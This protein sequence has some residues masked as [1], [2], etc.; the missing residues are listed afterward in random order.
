[1]VS[2]AS[3]FSFNICIHGL[4]SLLFSY[5]TFPLEHSI[6][7][8]W[9]ELLRYWSHHVPVHQTHIHVL[10]DALLFLSLVVFPQIRSSY[11]S[12]SHLST[13]QLDHV[14]FCDKPFNGFLLLLG[15]NWDSKTRIPKPF[16]VWP[17]PVSPAALSPSLC[18][19]CFLV[20]TVASIFPRCLATPFCSSFMAQRGFPWAPGKFRF[21]CYVF[22][23]LFSQSY[24]LLLFIEACVQVYRFQSTP[25]LPW[26]WA[27][28]APMS[29]QNSQQQVLAVRGTG[30]GGCWG[31]MVEALTAPLAVY[32]SHC[33]DPLMLQT[34]F[35]LA[36]HWF[37]KV[38]AY[39]TLTWFSSQLKKRKRKRFTMRGWWDSYSPWCCLTWGMIDIHLQGWQFRW[40]MLLAKWHNPEIPPRESEPLVT[41]FLSGS[42]CLWLLYF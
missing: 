39:P 28:R 37:F 22:S 31:S 32:L 10:M 16:M 26:A 19:C 20:W 11:Y 12:R 35:P 30:V 21:L 23:E 40:S 5:F 2:C 17:L 36:C 29:K 3:T 41:K 33:S 7:R 4:G 24:H 14:I 25:G 27:K 13:H 8:Q 9:I 34:Q 18:S 42:D 15:N 1:M 38:L 6:P